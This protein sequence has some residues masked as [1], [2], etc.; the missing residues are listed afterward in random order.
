M[1]RQSLEIKEIL[2][3]LD[4]MGKELDRIVDTM[5]KSLAVRVALLKKLSELA[6][7]EESEVIIER[8]ERISIKSRRR[9]N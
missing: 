6:T 3:N 2:S 7:T 9:V 8:T 5:N 4:G 1:T